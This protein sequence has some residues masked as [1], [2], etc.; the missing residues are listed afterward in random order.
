MNVAD[1]HLTNNSDIILSELDEKKEVILETIG[2]Q[3]EKYAK[4]AVPV[5]TGRLR[6]SIAYTVVGDDVYI[7]TNVDYGVWHEVGT[8][9][10]AT[11]GNGRKTPWI[12]IDENGV[13]HQTRGVKPKHYLKKAAS[14]HNKTYRQIIETVLKK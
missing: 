5:D 2:L 4:L 12:Y 9:I 14:E 8:G 10:Y 1:I 6:N 3:A 11:D 13:A 7:G